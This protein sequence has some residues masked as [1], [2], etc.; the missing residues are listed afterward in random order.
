M[1]QEAD[2]LHQWNDAKQRLESKIAKLKEM[3][4]SS[5]V[6]HCNTQSTLASN[7][8][9]SS[10]NNGAADEVGIENVD[11]NTNGTADG[12]GIGNDVS[13]AE[14]NESSAENDAVVLASLEDLLSGLDHIHAPTHRQSSHA[15]TR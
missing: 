6:S 14:G 11:E 9:I 7:G 8:I 13:A 5:N 15:K 1:T 12:V 2:T 3:N 10:S 4:E